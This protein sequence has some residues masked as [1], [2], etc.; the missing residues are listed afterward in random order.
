MDASQII[1]QLRTI[2]A[3][4]D[5]DEIIPARMNITYLI[6]SIDRDAKIDE[7]EVF[8]DSLRNDEFSIADLPAALR[9]LADSME[10]F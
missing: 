1:T 7:L 5:R 3:Q 4:V 2:H 8:V 6:A 9:R 10:P